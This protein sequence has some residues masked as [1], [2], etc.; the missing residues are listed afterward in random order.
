MSGSGPRASKRVT[1]LFSTATARGTLVVVLY[2]ADALIELIQRSTMQLNHVCFGII[3][4]SIAWTYSA[5][6]FT[7]SVWLNVGRRY[8]WQQMCQFLAIIRLFGVWV[9]ASTLVS[10]CSC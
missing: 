1:A 3:L 2:G 8:W 7:E 5:L 4:D 6:K 10:S 9:A